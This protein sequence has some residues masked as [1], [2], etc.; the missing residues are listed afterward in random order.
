[1][2]AIL[3][4]G[5]TPKMD[6][7]A[8]LNDAIRV[9]GELRGEAKKLKDSNESLQEKIKELKVCSVSYDRFIY[10][11]VQMRDGMLC[12]VTGSGCLGTSY[13]FIFFLVPFFP[14]GQTFYLDLIHPVE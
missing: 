2:G 13:C 1:M 10:G 7:S 8:I 4:P 6:K 12:D 9:V 11:A 5:K 14:S 3:E